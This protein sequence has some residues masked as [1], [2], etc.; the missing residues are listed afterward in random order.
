MTLDALLMKAAMDDH[1]RVLDAG[2]RYAG[3][4]VPSRRALRSASRRGWSRRR[5]NA[6]RSSLDTRVDLVVDNDIAPQLDASVPT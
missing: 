2:A 5:R 3:Y 1:R 6:A 4:D